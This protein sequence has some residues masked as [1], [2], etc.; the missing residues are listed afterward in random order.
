MKKTLLLAILSGAVHLASAGTTNLYIQDWGTTNGGSSVGGNGNINLVG[1]TGVA[2]TQTAGPYLGIFQA[3]GASDAGSGNP[4]PVN[5]VYFTGLTP[6]QSTPGMFYTTDSAGTGTGGDTAFTDIDPTQYT[7]LTLSVEVRGAATDTNYFAV[8]MGSQWYVSTNQLT[9]SG[10]LG[11]PVFTNAVVPFTNAAGAWRLLTINAT[12]VTIGAAPGSDL[13]GLIT[14]IGIVELPTSGGFNYN[15]LAITALGASVAPPVAPTLSGGVTPQYS[16]PGGGASFLVQ[17][18]GTQPLTFIWETNGVPL[19]SGGRYIGV[20]SNILTITNLVVGDDAIAYSVIV[21]NIAGAA[22]NNSLTLVLS[23]QPPELLY[24]ENFPYVGPSGNL[25]LSGVGWVSSASAGTSVGIYE[26][27]AGVG[28]VFSYSPTATTNIYYTTA[29]N[30]TGL[31]GLPFIDINPASYP[32]ITLQAGFVPGNAA[33]QVQGAISVYWAVAMNGTWYAS[34]NPINIT[35]TALSPYLPY[36]LG[37]DPTATNWNNLTITGTNAIIGS[38]AGSA[39]SGNITGV[40]LVVAHNTSTGS[41]MNFQNFQVLTN[42]SVGTAPSIGTGIPLAVTVPSGGGASFGV[43]ATGTQPFTYGWTTNG[44]AVHDGGRVSG[45][46]T[47]ILTIAD[48]TANDDNMQVV[49]FVTNSAGFDES[50]SVFGATPVTVT[51]PPVG[52]I[53]LEQFPFVGPVSGNYSLSTVGWTEAVPNNPNVIFQSQ[54]QTSE[55]SAFAFLGSAATTVYYTS[56]A[57]DTNQ[58]GLPFP[59]IRIAS[60]PS[61]TFSVDIAPS[62]S[63]SNVTAYIAVQMNNT[64]WYISASPLPVPTASDSGTYATYTLAFNPAASNWKNLTIATS[65][66]LIGSTAGSNLNG[67]M[68][69]AGLVFVTIGTGGTFNFDNFGITGIGL[70]GINT[71]M[72]TNGNLNLSWV[73]NPAVSLQSSTNLNNNASWQDV[74]NTSGLYSWPAPLNGPVRFYRLIQH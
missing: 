16:Y 68:T 19:Q 15:E 11:Y 2:V 67:I 23:N 47:A 24:A 32:A 27:A 25:P 62:F 57:I 7:N 49:A 37:F 73:G 64:N 35:L 29:T 74:P 53:Y 70:G 61:M 42:Q 5:T 44:V 45:S 65:G 51:N 21:T 9:G 31:S 20:N 36:Q 14:G 33:G 50:D 58:A 46:S 66:G 59:N 1:W 40:G 4:L 72:L 56:T 55:G 52:E 30:D 63:A 6:S 3:T 60:Y 8:R 34:K 39:L 13:S 69:G 17:A 43:T 71:G 48:L 10:T 41:D 54:A 22:T 18:T 26:A 38:Q 12:D 28:D